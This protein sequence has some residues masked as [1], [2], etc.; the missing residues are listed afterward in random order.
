MLRHSTDNRR[1]GSLGKQRVKEFRDAKK[2]MERDQEMGR[3][4]TLKEAKMAEE[5]SPVAKRAKKSTP[6]LKA[7][8][9]NNVR[10][11]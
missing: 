9:L 10:E 7:A 2:A 5:S 11:M 1:H 4:R 6:L 8:I 3:K